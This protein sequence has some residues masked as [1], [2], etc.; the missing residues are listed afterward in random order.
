[1][2]DAG[3]AALQV[4][5]A[6]G[7]DGTLDVLLGAAGPAA[8]VQLVRAAGPRGRLLSA[9]LGW[10]ADGVAVVELAEAA[11]LRRLRHGRRDPLGATSRG[12]GDLILAALDGG[13]RR[14]VVGVGGSAST[15]GGAGILTALGARLLDG[16]GAPVRP[17][18]GALAELATVD[19]SALDRRLQ[20]CAIEVAVDVD[21]PLYGPQGA[22]HVFG[23]QKG[24]DEAQVAALDGGLRHLAGLVERASGRHGLASQPGT[25]AAGGAGFALAA[26]GATLVGGAA[27]VC[28]LVSLD[29]TVED[30]SLVIT[31]EGRL[32]AQTAA[33]KAPAEV[34]R[35]A[36]AAGLPCIAIAGSVTAGAGDFSAAIS[37]EA[38]GADPRRH[39]RALLRAAGKEAVRRA[40]GFR[41]GAQ[42]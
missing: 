36:A 12:A 28:D 21:S 4:P 33:G 1:V 5:V 3:W 17:G 30:A 18:G 31:G 27:L 11:G 24:A 39:V 34:A 23:P 9:R 10:I 20:S 2:R 7:G 38:L 22:A 37:L 16:R 19:L 26:L 35:R 13:A 14:V 6:D 8:R 41:A 29:E 32:D 25:G 42:P 15:D 40:D